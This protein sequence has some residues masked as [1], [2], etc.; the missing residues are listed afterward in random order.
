LKKITYFSQKTFTA[1]EISAVS[2]LIRTC[3]AHD[4]THESI[5][6]SVNAAYTCNPS[7]RLFYTARAGK[8]LIGVTAL[9]IPTLKEAEISGFVHPS[10]R[11]KGVFKTLLAQAE[12]ELSAFNFPSLLFV[13]N[14]Q[15]RS[16]LQM[17]KNAEIPYDFT[18][19][20]MKLDTD[21]TYCK[22]GVTLKKA[23]KNS[24]NEFVDLNKNIFKETAENALMM[25]E[26]T[27]QSEDRHCY[28][29]HHN[30]S[31]IGMGC[32][33]YTK[34]EHAAFIFGFGIL[35]EYRGKGLGKLA[36]CEL[37]HFIHTNYKKPAGLEVN[38]RNQAALSLYTS[39]GFKTESAY[40]Y[41]RRPVISRSL[42][43]AS[44]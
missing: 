17:L 34:S 22:T 26:S 35:P 4:K 6:I 24:V 31:V 38:S 28:S 42:E 10:Y 41:Y 12:A 37:V 39:M 33:A 8:E 11:R 30:N 19:F 25:L 43:E 32:I 40:H 21:I 3:S 36:L 27:F 18:E 5:D 16:G 13:C 44:Q 2:K 9:F 7:L 14:N 23:Y 29:I 20:S 1:A 15:S